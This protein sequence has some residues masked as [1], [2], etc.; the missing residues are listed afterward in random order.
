MP[1]FILK[2]K[3]NCKCVTIYC[4]WI[5]YINWKMVILTEYIVY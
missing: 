1:D 3:Q 2:R 4:C 5:E